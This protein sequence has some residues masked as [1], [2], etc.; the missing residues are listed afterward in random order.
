MAQVFQSPHIQLPHLQEC[1]EEIPAELLLLSEEQESEPLPPFKDFEW[2]RAEEVAR[3]LRIGDLI[4]FQRIEDKRYIHWAVYIGLCNGGVKSVV[5]YSPGDGRDFENKAGNGTGAGACGESEF[6]IVRIYPFFE[7]AGQSLCRVNNSADTKAPAFTPEEIKERALSKVGS[8]GYSM[9]F[10]NCEHFAKWCR[11]NCSESEQATFYSRIVGSDP[12]SSTAES[13]PLSQSSVGSKARVVSRR[14]QIWSNFTEEIDAT[15]CT[16]VVCRE[17]FQ[18]SIYGKHTFVSLEE[19]ASNKEQPAAKLR[20]FDITLTPR[21]K[22]EKIQEALTSA[23]AISGYS[24]SMFVH[25]LMRA[26]FTALNLNVEV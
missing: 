6:T 5:H 18:A 3:T 23:L 10:N 21:T 19:E 4:E 22:S 26:L 15:G 7:T 9:F 12:M 17:C 16:I 13:S 20:R 1:R 24:I 14:G 11:N 25:P 8:K 2:R